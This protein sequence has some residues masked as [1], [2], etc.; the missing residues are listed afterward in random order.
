MIGFLY[1]FHH[2]LTK[3]ILLMFQD[4]LFKMLDVNIQT[5]PFRELRTLIA[6]MT[7]RSPEIGAELVHRYRNYLSQFLKEHVKETPSFLLGVVK[8]SSSVGNEIIESNKNLMF[9]LIKEQQHD[10]TLGDIGSFLSA[11]AIASPSLAKTI[12]HTHQ[13]LLFYLFLTKGSEEPIY[14]IG[15]FFS[16]LSE[17]A[18]QIATEIIQ[19]HKDLLIKLIGEKLQTKDSNGKS[20]FHGIGLLLFEI[21][22]VSLPIAKEIAQIYKE[23]IYD[24]FTS[25][26][27]SPYLLSL[28]NLFLGI[29]K[30]SEEMAYDLILKNQDALQKKLQSAS[31]AEFQDFLSEIAKVSESFAK[32]IASLQSI[33]RENP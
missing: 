28:R 16:G 20:K 12:V 13:E 21:A 19:T 33:P 31:Q 5:L 24:E 14:R 9:N 8:A 7:N 26:L 4:T 1:S 10:L 6:G 18:P 22:S 17:A 3:T 32:K 27:R 25:D 23:Y 30:T 29:V 2:E 11:V 15:L